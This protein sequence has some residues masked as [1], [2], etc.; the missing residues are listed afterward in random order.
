MPVEEEKIE[1]KEIRKRS[2]NCCCLVDKSRRN[3]LRQKGDESKTATE[4]EV[5]SWC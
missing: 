1:K 2:A 3:C 4:K 5:D